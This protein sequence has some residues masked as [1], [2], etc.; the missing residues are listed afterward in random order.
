MPPE[1][2][3]V[4]WRPQ[5]PS[6]E[7]LR[8]AHLA[9]CDGIDSVNNLWSLYGAG[10]ARGKGGA[11]THEHQDLLRAMVV[12]AGAALDATAK[13]V[14][15]DSLYPLVERNEGSR[16]EAQKH[17]KR[18]VLGE[19]E[20]GSTDRL[21]EALLADSPRRRI[22]EFIIADLT[23]GSLQ[24]VEQ[25]RKATAL[26][27]LGSEF[28]KGNAKE[29][30]DAFE[31]RN[32]IVHEMDALKAAPAARGKKRRRQRKKDE[33]FGF[34]KSLLEAAHELVEGVDGLLGDSGA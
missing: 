15:A 12:M 17:V 30:K 14:I 11:P 19:L 32:Q 6:T 26:L 7:C 34:A 27:G 29:L 8:S 9:L 21:A 3:E 22:V 23:G 25:L 2:Q 16:T 24:S 4:M 20:K 31:A 33:M 13:R 5:A 18:S 10:T 1:P 28:A